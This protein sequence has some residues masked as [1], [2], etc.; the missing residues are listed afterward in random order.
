MAELSM[1]PQN[2]V[3]VTDQEIAQ[4]LLAMM[5]EIEDH[6]D[7]QEVYANFDIP[8]EILARIQK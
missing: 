7:I 2:R 5:D 4:R 8:E 3:E 6:D 1:I